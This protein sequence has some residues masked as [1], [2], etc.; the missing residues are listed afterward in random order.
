MS[1]TAKARSINHWGAGI[2]ILGLIF[3]LAPAA[4]EVGCGI[5]AVGIAYFAASRRR[6][7]LW[8]ALCIIPILGALSA[9]TLLA[10]LPPPPEDER[11]GHSGWL[12]SPHLWAA[13]LFIF[14]LVAWM[15]LNPSAV[16]YRAKAVKQSGLERTDSGRSPK[17][18][19]TGLIRGNPA[20][21]MVAG[22][23]GEGGGSPPSRG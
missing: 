3:S 11:A 2:A 8:G 16:F 4:T 12:L 15:N 6:H 19:L 10:I 1:F 18:L 13:L 9:L 5:S 20:Y 21:E 23:C 7:P 14:F 17:S 22:F